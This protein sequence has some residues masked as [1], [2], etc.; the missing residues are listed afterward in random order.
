MAGKTY[1]IAL[2]IKGAVDASLGKSCVSAAGELGK[3]AVHAKGLNTQI[4]NVAGYERQRT[5][6]LGVA[7][8]YREAQQKLRELS[9][10]HA[11]NPTKK[12]EREMHAAATSVEKLSKS[13]QTQSAKLAEMRGVLQG[14]GVDTKCLAGEQTRLAAEQ[15][16]VAAQADKIRV[17]QERLQGSKDALAASKARLAGMR[18]EILAS[19][20]IVMALRAP[21]KAAADFEQALAKVKAVSG[22]S[23]E[24][25]KLLSEQAR[26]LGRDTQFSASQAA[27]GQELLARAGFKTAEILSAMPGLLDMAAA[28]G[29]EL[30]E[31]TNIAASTLRGFNLGADQTA[32]VA[33]TLAKTSA[34]S[35]TSIATLGESMKYVAPVASGLGISLEEVS[36]MIGVMGDA[37]IKGSQAGTALRG[38]LIRLSKEPRQAAAALE[39]L[40]VKARDASGNM[41]AIP[42]LMDEL[43]EKMKNMGSAE[44]MEHLSKIFGTEAAAG[45]LALME[46]VKTGKLE[47]LT[48]KI[49]ASA[50]AAAEMARI[51]NDTAQGAMKRLSSASESLMIDLGNVLLP[52]F[53]SG[54]DSLAG[55]TATLSSLSQEFPMVTKVIVGGVAALGA[56]KVAVTAGKLA[57]TAAKLPFQH[58]KVMI[59]TLRLSTVMSGQASVLAAAKTKIMTVATG[60]QA[61][62]QKVLNVAMRAGSALWDAGKLVLYHGKQLAIGVATKGWAAAQWVLNAAMNANPIGLVIAG[63]AALAAG[64]YALWKNWDEVC[65]GMAA[66]WEWLTDLVSSGWEWIKGL[67]S[68]EGAGD[69]WGW[70]TAP[71]TGAMNLIHGGW[72]GIKGLFSGFPDFIGGTLGGLTDIIFAPFKAAFSLIEGAIDWIKGVWNSFMSLFSGDLG[73]I[74]AAT[75][76]KVEA[77]AA[78]LSARLGDDFALAGYATGGIVTSPQIAMIGEA[79]TEIVLPVDRPSRG[80]PLWKAAGEMMGISFGE[81]QGGDVNT[82]HTF[83]PVVHINVSGSDASPG[84]IAQAVEE[85]LRRLSR[86]E[87][88]TSFA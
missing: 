75:N 32:R 19:A 23:G 36:A 50:G 67:F 44:K 14:A 70:I 76:A 20:G 57:W 56:Y 82:S 62:A 22:A 24:E 45:M 12:T 61:A 42:S 39:S 78:S 29:M 58:A 16:K 80:I 60:A 87:A 48:E 46:S 27:A 79:G 5:A 18:G 85:A 41:R 17:A 69:L 7:K 38:A 10:A 37:G 34:S 8:A 66:G 55:F 13:Y 77:E 33:D 68:W 59:D 47:E 3:L 40:G 73:K 52:T 74:D 81:G 21:I 15:A 6:T 31:A 25:M 1:Q 49:N 88:R 71:F 64:A 4:A 9:A 84:A 26:T 35:N 11:Q 51:M 86:E 2:A 63:V 43:S 65:S 30:A 54:V 72:A 53:A 28:E 83:A